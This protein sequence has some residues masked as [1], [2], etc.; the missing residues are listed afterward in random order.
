MNTISSMPGTRP[1][2]TSVHPTDD[3][4]YDYGHGRLGEVESS[5]LDRHLAQCPACARKIERGRRLLTVLGGLRPA[6]HGEAQHREWLRRAILEA[7]RRARESSRQRLN[8]WAAQASALAGLV[9]QWTP[10]ASRV[11]AQLE[12]VRSFI[13]SSAWHLEAGL[14]PTKP[15]NTWEPHGSAWPAAADR[16][17]I[18][19]RH[20]PSNQPSPLLVFAPADQPGRPEVRMA[21]RG[22]G[23][24]DRVASFTARRPGRYLV[25]F[26]P[27]S[28]KGDGP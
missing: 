16:I 4:L 10:S 24:P 13:G 23:R 6:A 5:L 12:L 8:H 21:R 14:A 20:W 3:Q 19:V 22:A 2:P 7:A 9:L 25:G 27:T 18:L 17:G 28:P 15:L 11:P 1:G 26:E